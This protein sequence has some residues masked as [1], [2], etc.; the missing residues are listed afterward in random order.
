M[1]LS[2]SGLHHAAE[3][4]SLSNRADAKKEIDTM[5][6]QF[7]ST[8]PC[9]P[10]Q[11]AWTELEHHEIEDIHLQMKDPALRRIADICIEP[12][13]RLGASIEI[14]KLTLAIQTITD[15]RLDNGRASL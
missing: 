4:A 8:R 3:P 5:S 1:Q 10:K 12:A 11:Q 9:L 14:K 13:A 7:L 2:I 15:R 6:N